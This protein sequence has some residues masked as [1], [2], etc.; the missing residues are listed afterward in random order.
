MPHNDASNSPHMLPGDDTRH[1]V[2]REYKF[3][4][5]TTGRYLRTPGGAPLN[6][7]F[8]ENSA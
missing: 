5:V 4:H 2:S 7:V 1:P 8:A 6:P 3:S